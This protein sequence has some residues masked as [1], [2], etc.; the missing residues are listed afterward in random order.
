VYEF[1]VELEEVYLPRLYQ[2][3]YWYN[4]RALP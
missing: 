2:Q 4:F 3:L 1:N